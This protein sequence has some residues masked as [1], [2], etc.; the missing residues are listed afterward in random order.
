MTAVTVR[1]VDSGQAEGDAPPPGTEIVRPLR[2]VQAVRD[3][4]AQQFAD[5]AEVAVSRSGRAWAWALGESTI[6]PVSDRPTAVPPSRSEIEVEIAVADD[7][8]VCDGRENRVD[9]AA[10]AAILRWL[11]GDDDHV[12]VRGENRGE[13]VG[14]FGDIVQS[15]EQIASVLTLATHGQ[16]RAALQARDV[17]SDSDDRQLARQ[18][19]DYL[20]GV[21]T[22]LAWVLGRQTETPIT[23]VTSREPTTQNLKSERVHAEDV[24]EQAR[25]SWITRQALPASY[26][27]AVT[28]S[29]DWLLGDSTISPVAESPS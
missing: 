19:A 26:G 3:R 28:R 1:S 8:R 24:I 23:Q 29:V 25:D 20:G 9:A 13:L 7:R 16:R 6:A 11:I 18:K 14:G 21:A 27:E 17:T 22:T 5:P 12:P 2:H 10:A 15:R 4:H